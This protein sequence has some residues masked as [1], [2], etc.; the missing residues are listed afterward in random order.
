MTPE[1]FG[2]VAANKALPVAVVSVG[3]YRDG[4]TW[5]PRE[6]TPAQAALSLLENTVSARRRPEAAL[7]ALRVAVAGARVVRG[8][9]GEAADVAQRLLALAESA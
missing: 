5:R 4:A 6:M 2:S 9:R 8:D 7:S 1:E 3:S